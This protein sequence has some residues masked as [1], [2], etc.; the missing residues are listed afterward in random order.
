[1]QLTDNHERV[2][3]PLKRPR[4]TCYF[5]R[6]Y[7]TLRAFVGGIPVIQISESAAQ[8]IASL[9]KEEGRDDS[10]FLRVRVKKGGCSGLSY[11]MDFDTQLEPTDKVFESYGQK[12]A[13][14]SESFLYLIGM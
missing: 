5:T 12:I 10:V 2:T 11:K 6:I 13:V 3:R 14:D 8:K 7:D 9:K 4:Q 1:Q